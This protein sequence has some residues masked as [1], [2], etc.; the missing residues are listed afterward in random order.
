[1]NEKVRNITMDIK[2]CCIVPDSGITIIEQ[3]NNCYAQLTNYLE[4]QEITKNHVVK[5]TVFVSNGDIKS[6]LSEKKIILETTQKYFNTII[7]ISVIPQ[8]PLN[9]TLIAIEITILPSADNFEIANKSVKNI[10]YLVIQTSD[11]KQVIAC[12]MG[13][14]REK[15]D[16]YLQSSNAFEQ[17]ELILTAENMDFSHIVR[18][19]NYIE[20]IVGYTYKDQHY[21]IFNDVRSFYYDKS[22]F[23]HG[24]PAATG[25]GMETAGIIIDFIAIQEK[26]SNVTIFP[27]KSPVQT[28]AHTYSKEVLEHNSQA[29]SVVETTPKFERAKAI[30]SHNQYLIMVSGTAAIKGQYSVNNNDAAE[31]A[32]LTMENIFR[33]VS[34]ENLKKHS[35]LITSQKAEPCYFRVY[36]KNPD[37]YLKVKS[38]CEKY[39]TNTDIVY[40]KADICRKELSVEIE[41]IFTVDI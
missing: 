40:L 24:Y 9:K 8:A 28:D 25:I 30:V 10:N 17:M 3:L 1:M 16:I 37:D 39:S 14:D 4:K 23:I 32:I 13:T 11:Y 33:L 7:P 20:N 6:Y 31:Q 26:G 22:N 18:Q 29:K 38:A 34:T 27:I 2:K 19:W 36:I 41:G 5:I 35:N 21:Q 15:T 12:G